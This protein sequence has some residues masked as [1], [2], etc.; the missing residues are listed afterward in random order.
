[1]SVK[2]FKKRLCSTSNGSICIE[3]AEH[4]IARTYVSKGKEGRDHNGGEKTYTIFTKNL[5]SC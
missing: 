1:M 4:V 3:V 2:L 5:S